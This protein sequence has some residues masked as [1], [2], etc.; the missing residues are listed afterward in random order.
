M[1]RCVIPS[2]AGTGTRATWE[3]RS[4]TPSTVARASQLRGRYPQPGQVERGDLPLAVHLAIGLMI[5]P[6]SVK[7]PVRRADD[8]LHRPDS[9]R[10]V[11]RGQFQYR[12]MSLVDGLRR[13]QNPVRDVLSD[14]VDAGVLPAGLA[15]A[16]T[17]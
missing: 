6:E 2:K 13:M 14:L 5:M 1:V 10:R 16:S 7:H 15:V 8:I 11:F 4:A 9:A 12:S 3:K 17:H